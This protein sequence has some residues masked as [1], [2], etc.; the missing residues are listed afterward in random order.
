MKRLKQLLSVFNRGHASFVGSSAL[1]QIFPLA[2]AP[3]IARLYTPEEF[4]TYAVFFALASILAGISALALTN[5]I[6]LETDERQ[7]VHATF[8]SLGVV[9]AFC[10]FLT[11]SMLVSPQ[12]AKVHLFGA[13]VTP[14]LPW[15]GLTVLV[16]GAFNCL[17][18]WA[19]RAE[20]F[21][22]L[23]RNK[24]VLGLATSG[25]QI[26]IGL[27]QPGAMGF[28]A[29]NLLG[30]AAA[31]L[32][33]TGPFILEARRLRPAF[34]LK[35][36]FRQFLKHRALPLWT[37]PATLVNTA[38][39]FLPEL[40][41][42]RLFGVA[43]LG[44]FSLA[45]RMINFPLNFLATSVQDIFRQQ[46]A[47]EFAERGHCR[48]TFNRFFILMSV[49]AVALLLPVIILVPMVFPIIFGRQWDQAGGLIQAIGLLII[50]RFV[51][52]PLS[53]VW[54]IRGHQKLDFLWQL[55]LLLLSFASF[56][57]PGHVFSGL[58]LKD[59][60]WIYS[61]SVGAW[62]GVCLFVSHQLAHR[63]RPPTPPPAFGVDPVLPSP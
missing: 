60:L 56:A 50:V 19:I 53:Y 47:L 35:S 24:L 63:Q 27:S 46:A 13:P 45:N 20:R 52:S 32:L 59:V 57:L 44:Q 8:L 29:A 41:I 22:L 49:V 14:F 31:I 12:A 3:I 16:S 25:L 34:G 23:A 17:Y 54:I 55:G 10:I 30:Y 62:Y 43:Q 40:M 36:A 38:C 48:A 18:A 9:A 7:A 6:L 15:L 11:A 2:T 51:S 58:S 37:L 42:N 61:V 21:P 5:A 26:G 33:L 1:V 39:S 28:I 4:G